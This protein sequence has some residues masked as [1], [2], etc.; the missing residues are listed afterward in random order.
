[1]IYGFNLHIPNQYVGSIHKWIGTA[2]AI[3]A[4]WSYVKTCTVKPGIIDK[5]NVN[6]IIKKYPYDGILFQQENK[7][8]TC[9]LKKYFFSY[10][11]FKKLKF[12]LIL[13]NIMILTNQ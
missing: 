9:K 6:Q 10:K 13:I 2:V 3:F 1:M 12:I 11:I 7:C 8:S 5:S 4:F